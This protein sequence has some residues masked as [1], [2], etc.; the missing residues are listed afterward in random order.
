[1]DSGNTLIKGAETI[2]L[3]CRLNINNKKNIPVRSSEMGL[4]ILIVKSE[5]PV[6]P[7]LAADFFKVS[8]PMIATMIASLT[9]QEYLTKKPSTDDKRKYILVPEQKAVDLV[10]STYTEYFK[11]MQLLSHEMGEKKFRELIALL[12]EAN[13]YLLKGE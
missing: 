1:M 6:T 7:V 10:E 12:S 2:S 3:F 4:L 13:A 8:K 11:V 9:R 5:T